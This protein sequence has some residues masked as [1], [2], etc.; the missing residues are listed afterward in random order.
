ME[1]ENQ[2]IPHSR[3]K[4]SVH[5]IGLKGRSLGLPSPNL[6]DNYT[7]WTPDGYNADS[8]GFSITKL[9]RKCKADK[10]RRL[11]FFIRFMWMNA[12]AF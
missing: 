9:V 6:I 12:Q 5:V 3:F 4:W 2:I 11:I 8:R 1:T 7:G 10:L